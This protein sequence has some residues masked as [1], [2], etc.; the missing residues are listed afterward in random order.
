MK[1][2]SVD[3]TPKKTKEEIEEENETEEREAEVQVQGLI[4]NEENL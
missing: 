2:I 4:T 1:S 3:L